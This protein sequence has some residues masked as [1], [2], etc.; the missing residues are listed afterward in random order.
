MTSILD[1]R[2][3]PEAREGFRWDALWDLVDGNRERLNLA[4]ECVD[5]HVGKGTALRIQ[6]ADGRREEH[7]FGALAEWSSRFAHLLEAEGIVRGDRVAIM[8]EP[9]LAFYGAVFGTVKRGAIAVPLFTLFGPEGLALRIDDCRPR[10]L[11]VERDAERWRAQFSEVSV[12]AVEDLAERLRAAPARYT[13][14]PRPTSSRCSS[15]RR[16]PPAPCRRRCG[17]RTARW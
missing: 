13:P 7:D 16:A 5:R 14:P 9:S 12:V 4:H 17:T 15:T 10:M 11:L 6:F 3:Y 1:V 2:R 8:L